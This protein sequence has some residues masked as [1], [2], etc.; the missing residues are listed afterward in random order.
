MK[1]RHLFAFLLGLAPILAHLLAPAASAAATDPTVA[2][3]AELDYAQL[4]AEGNDTA[5]LK[6]SL[7]PAHLRRDYER[8]PL[9]LAIVLDRSGSMNGAKIEMAKR[10]IHRAFQT[11][12]PHDYVSIV[13]YNNSARTLLPLTQVRRV[14][15][16][17]AYIDRIHA[18]GGTAIYAGVNL[19]AAELRPALNDSAGINRILLLSDGLANEGPSSVRDFKLLGQSLAREGI[20]VSTIG[21]GLGYNEDLMA[22]LSAAGQGNVYF[23]ETANDLPR[24]FDSELGDASSIV[25]QNA[26]IEIECLHGFQPLRIIGRDGRVQGNR[27]TLDIKHL[28]AGQEKF[29]LI[30]VRNPGGKAHSTQ[31]IAAI[32]TRYQDIDSEQTY[33][34]NH[35]A[36]TTF[37]A[38]R[39]EKEKSVNIDVQRQVVYNY[40]AIA[41]DEAVALADQGK[42]PQA[43]AALSEL[44]DWIATNNTVWN[45]A[46]I[47]EKRLALESTA[48]TL[49]TQG[50]D[51]KSRKEMRS[52][53]YQTRSQQKSY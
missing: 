49:E 15:N 19:G 7:L 9:N 43:T 12:Q 8:P 16:P 44:E 3:T 52:S 46:E 40:I 6:V 34:V 25:A 24:I 48:T 51:N 39:Q 21:L 27:V 53:S 30:E 41:Q 18:D 36:T 2:L 17:S 13:A 20:T 45:D 33:A 11:L 22:G 26:V 31:E 42:V 37:A 23:V 50:L 38:D 1:H 32:T 35:T 4:S 29:A 5:I 10:A 47:E 14:S 28:Y